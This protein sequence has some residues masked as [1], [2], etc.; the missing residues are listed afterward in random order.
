M[1]VRPFSSVPGFSQLFRDYNAGENAALSR[2]PTT[3]HLFT[4][5]AL[6]QTKAHTHR[7]RTEVTGAVRETMAE[8][9]LTPQQEENLQRLSQSNT[10]TVITGQQVGLL[11]GHLYTILKAWT[12]VE[13]AKKVAAAHPSLQAVPIFWVADNDHDI[14]E[15]AVVSLLDAQGA[16]HELRLHWQDGLPEKVSVSD[17]NFDAGVKDIVEQVQTLLPDTSW[18]PHIMDVLQSVYVPGKPVT[19][20]FLHILQMLLAD[21]GVIFVTASSLQRRGLFAP[22]ARQEICHPEQTAQALAQ[23][24]NYLTTHGYH[25][26]AQ[27]TPTNIFIHEQ[28]KRLKVSRLQD[29]MYQLG[30]RTLTQADLLTLMEQHPESVTP[31]VLLRPVIQDHIFPNCCYIGGPGEVSYFAQL[32]ELYAA[33]DVVPAAVIA[34]HSISILEGRSTQFFE[35]HPLPIEHFFQSYEAFERE[36]VRLLENPA[37]AEAFDVAEQQQEELFRHLSSLIIPL[38]PTLGATVDKTKNH[39]LQALNELHGKVRKAQ[40]RQEETT[41]S[42][43][44]K[45]HNLLYPLNTLQERSLSF[46]YF[47]NKYGQEVCSAMM[48]SVVAEPPNQHY[49]VSM[50]TITTG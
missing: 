10:L 28:G 43:A 42:K 33:M 5:T 11:G 49:I 7:Y 32:P 41:M 9:R 6:W 20:A 40:K 37:I 24:A 21:T 39:I 1:I 48:Q 50:E 13:Y 19:T 31:N 38:E 25:V 16:A 23:A 3:P 35:K 34:R 29:G 47:V 17:L 46:L 14:A 45:I 4:D 36:L 15:T 26:Q 30:S 44:R 2:Y 27:T 22:I 12:A 8:L 18:K